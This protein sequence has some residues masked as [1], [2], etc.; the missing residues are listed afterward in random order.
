[1]S[2]SI[3]ARFGKWRC[4]HERRECR[5]A[6]AMAKPDASQ[7]LA[8]IVRRLATQ[9]SCTPAMTQPAATR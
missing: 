1:M 3:A 9:A 4:R 7:V 6:T 2:Q 5:R 8:T